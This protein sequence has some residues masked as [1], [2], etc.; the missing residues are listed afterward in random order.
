MPGPVGL[1]QNFAMGGYDPNSYGQ[2]I[3]PLLAQRALLGGP[4]AAVPQPAAPGVRPPTQPGYDPALVGGMLEMNAMAPEEEAIAR[5]QKLADTLRGGAISNL[6]TPGGL[7][8]TPIGAGLQGAAN[9][10]ALKNAGTMSDAAR[11]S[12]RNMGVQRGDIARKYFAGL[13]GRQ[14][15]NTPGPGIFGGEGE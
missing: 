14:P 8:S 6:T 2:P 4:T 3:N 15:D 11:L 7:G 5:Q 13:T 9:I 12:A 1:P 10:L